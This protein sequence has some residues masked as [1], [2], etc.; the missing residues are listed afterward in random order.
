M[1]GKKQRRLNIISDLSSHLA[2]F[3][4]VIIGDGICY[5]QYDSKTKRQHV[6]ENKRFTNTKNVAVI[7]Q[8]H[9]YLIFLSHV[10]TTIRDV[11]CKKCFRILDKQLA[12]MPISTIRLIR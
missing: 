10:V 3:D 1:M 7:Y 6:K 4:R 5:L 12:I 8:N 9:E 11:V 2:V